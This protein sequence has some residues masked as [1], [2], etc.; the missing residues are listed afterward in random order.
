MVY[1]VHVRRDDY[2]AEGPIN[3]D[4]HPDVAVIKHGRRV[5]DNFKRQYGNWSGPN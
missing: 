4:R 5:Q 2:P 1:A 3:F